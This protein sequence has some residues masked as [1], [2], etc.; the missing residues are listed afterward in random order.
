MVKNCSY[1]VIVVGKERKAF[2]LF[3]T[4]DLS[5]AKKLCKEESLKEINYLM[6]V[7][8]INASNGVIL[9]T[10]M[11]S[12]ELFKNFRDYHSLYNWLMDEKENYYTKKKVKT[13][14][15]DR[16]V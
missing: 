14:V 11:F 16:Y 4:N 10:E 8:V 12:I 1:N 7:Y 5:E 3:E 2:V 15:R 9:H 6:P 13:V